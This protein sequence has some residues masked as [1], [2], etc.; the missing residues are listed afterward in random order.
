MNNISYNF[1]IQEINE[2]TSQ[3]VL[4]YSNL[5]GVEKHSILGIVVPI[6]IAI[7]GVS[8]KFY[9]KHQNQQKKLNGLFNVTWKNSRSIKKDKILGNRPF[10][11]YYYVRDEDE[12]VRDCLK[13]EQSVLIVGS[14]LGGKTRM[15]YE[16]L[17]KSKKYVLIIPRAKDIDIESFILPKRL[18]VWK[19]KIMFIDDL[20]RFA[21][22]KNFEYIFEVCRKNKINLIVTCRSEIEYAKTKKIMLDKNINLE[23][24][25]FDE[26]IELKEISEEQGKEVAEKMG[27]NW[28]E[29]RFN[30]T[31]GSIFM[32]LAEMNKR[33]SECTPEE[34]SI[35]K[36]IKKLYIC[37]VYD[38]GQIFQLDQI[39]IVSENEG[40]KKEKYQWKELITNLCKKEFIK[41]D[42]KELDKIWAEEVYLEDIVKLNY[43]DLRIF[44]EMLSTF[45]QFP[46]ELFKIGNRAYD[47]GSVVLQKAKCMKIAIEAYQNALK[48]R[49]VEQFPMNYAMIQ[50]NIGTAY[51]TLAEVEDKAQNCKKAIEAYQNALKIRTVEQFP[52]DYAMTQNNLDRII[53]FCKINDI[54]I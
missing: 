48:I 44:E 35:L 43:S 10:D 46:E 5:S 26:I 40:I 4:T 33:F 41:I 15:V 14:P 28:N 18:R 24:E 9:E 47:I 22:L 17:R 36:A 13:K 54:E 39:K 31:I 50:N 27:W 11:E 25:I 7:I 16:A 12:K 21:E 49:T 42:E 19:P 37:G 34:K 30:R 29:I 52:M 3:L 6:L 23:T 32:P 53:N 8:Y 38:E 20:H 2:S 45:K 51:S 1:P